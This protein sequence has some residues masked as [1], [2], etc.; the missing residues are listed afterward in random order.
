V[1]L[2]HRLLFLGVLVLW[3]VYAKNVLL[4]PVTAIVVEPTLSYIAMSLITFAGGW[5]LWKLVM[6]K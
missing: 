2:F 6:R 1:K 4:S 3:I 5:I